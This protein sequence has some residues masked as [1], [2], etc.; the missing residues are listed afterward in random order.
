MSATTD[1]QSLPETD[2]QPVETHDRSASPLPPPQPTPVSPVS[3]QAWWGLRRSDNVV[4]VALV[5]TCLTFAVWHWGRLSGWGLREIEI[6][7]PVE[8]V[9][10]YQLDVNSAT[11]VEWMQLPGIGETLARRIVENREIHGPFSSIED[12]QR[13]KGI[14]VKTLAKLRPWMTIK[15]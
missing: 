7:R 5:I 15:E 10:E 6:N 14:G 3:G 1:S 11:W 13:V 2:P 9:F 12:V 4:G 8:K